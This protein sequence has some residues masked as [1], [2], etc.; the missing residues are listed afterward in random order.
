METLIFTRDEIESILTPS[1]A[2]KAVHRAFK[3]CALGQADMPP[4]SYLYFKKGDLRTM[5]AY[6]H[7]QGLNIAGTKCVNVHPENYRV[8]LPSVMAV[9]VLVDPKTGFP[10]AVMDGTC[11]TRMRTGAA[12]ALAAKLLSIKKAQVAGFVGFGVQARTQLACLLEVRK[13]QKI[14]V[15]ENGLKNGSASRFRAWA[16]K[17]FHLESTISTDIDEVTTDVDILTTTTPSRKPLVHHVTPGTHINAIGADAKG[18]QEISPRILRNAM[19]VIDDW[20]QASHSGEINVPLKKRR[21]FRKHIHGTLGEIAAGLKQ[22]RGSDGEITV[23]DSTGL[24]IQDVS[25][26]FTVYKALKDR[27]DVRRVAFF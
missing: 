11:I 5:P 26:A 17:T 19:I 23:F 14:K 16:E 3:A 12:G 15:W 6:I 21:L 8:N 27:E 24:A 1:L 2:I 10:L 7:G 4:K 20:V 13:I 9:I 18:K 25:C 22:G